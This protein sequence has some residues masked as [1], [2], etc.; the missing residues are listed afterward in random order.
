MTKNICEVF[1]SSGYIGTAYTYTP[2]GEVTSSGSTVQPIQW[3]SEYSDTELGL[4]YYNYR[5]YNPSDGRWIRRDIIEEQNSLNM[6]LI[7]SNTVIYHTDYLGAMDPIYG[8]YM[9]NA[10]IAKNR[11]E[12]E[13]D[14][15][16]EEDGKLS[17]V[18]GAYE[19]IFSTNPRKVIWVDLAKCSAVV[20]YSN[21]GIDPCSKNQ[22]SSGIIDKP[23]DLYSSSNMDIAG[24][25]RISVHFNYTLTRKCKKWHLKGTFTADDD[26]FN[27]D[28][29]KWG[30]RDGSGSTH[31]PKERVTRIVGKYFPGIPFTVK[32]KPYDVDISGECE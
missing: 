32:F 2:Y 13:P 26:P 4:V 10:G 15:K 25:G 8:G 17:Y 14:E 1:N 11:K 31:Y 21:M 18:E 20:N 27:F 7:G 6:Y 24:P 29:K 30:E 19:Y 23:L 16:I 5:H 9:F 12:N 3:S 28:E 22:A